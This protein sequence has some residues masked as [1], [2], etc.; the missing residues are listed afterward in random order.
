MQI[1]SSG[2]KFHPAGAPDFLPIPQSRNLQLARP[3]QIVERAYRHV[4]HFRER[5]LDQRGAG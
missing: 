5:V 1:H 2:E 4:P 3:R